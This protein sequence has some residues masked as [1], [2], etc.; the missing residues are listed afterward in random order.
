[1]KKNVDHTYSTGCTRSIEVAL[2]N[3][4]ETPLRKGAGL[5]DLF[6]A[7][8][9]IVI[10]LTLPNRTPISEN[11]SIQTLPPPPVTGVW[12]VPDFAPLAECAIGP[13]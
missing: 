9:P 5:R 4:L 1:V 8:A 6:L 3:R 13:H 2:A 10:H 11:S 7:A 12:G